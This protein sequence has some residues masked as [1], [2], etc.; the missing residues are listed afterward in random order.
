MRITYLL[1]LALIGSY[2][3]VGFFAPTGDV[4]QNYGFSGNSLLQGELWV[5]VTSI[6]LHGGPAHL[7][8]NCI[9]LF[10]FGRALEDE[11]STKSYLTI[12]FLGGI[13]GNLVVLF[14]YP[15]NEIVIG[16]SGAVF[17]IMGMGIL[18]APFDFVVYPALMPLPLALVGIVIA[19]SEVLAFI[20]GVDGNIAHVAHLGGLATGLVF[21]LREGKT[22]KGLVVLGVIFLILLL[23]PNL[24][25]VIS[26]L[27]YLNFVK[28]IVGGI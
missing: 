19:V 5:L 12:F 3:F 14:R 4:F 16:A 22:M 7:V 1:I 2:I 27:S 6:F 8:L 11:I 23:L 13:V 21:G 25:P 9:A 18:L 17:A 26:K 20:T 10:F 15:A 24:W 28:G